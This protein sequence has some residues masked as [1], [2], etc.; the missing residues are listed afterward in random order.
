[1]A[2]AAAVF[3]EIDTDGSGSITP[4]ELS[5][6]LSDLGFEEEE[7]T[8]LFIT[9]DTDG[10]GNITEEEFVK[11]FEQYQEFVAEDDLP[12]C[13]EGPSASIPGVAN[14]HVGGDAKPPAPPP[15]PPA[16]S[17]APVDEE[18]CSSTSTP[19]SSDDEDDFPMC[20]E[21]APNTISGVPNPGA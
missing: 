7:I 15:P 20:V 21:S 2:D 1:M 8:Q 13:F 4:A 18:S 12:I 19:S 3:A 6:R 14:P 9:L 17:D 16:P 5:C 10:D 11:G